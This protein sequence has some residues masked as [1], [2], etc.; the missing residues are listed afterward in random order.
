MRNFFDS[1]ESDNYSLRMLVA[2]FVDKIKSIFK[3]NNPIDLV[4]EFEKWLKFFAIEKAKLCENINT[5]I[6]KEIEGKPN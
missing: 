3:L 4:N 2:S 1:L 6:T 5:K